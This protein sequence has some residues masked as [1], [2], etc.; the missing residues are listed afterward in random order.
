MNFELEVKECSG[1]L[2]AEPALWM[3]RFLARNKK[4]YESYTPRISGLFLSCLTAAQTKDES[5]IRELAGRLGCDSEIREGMMSCI[6]GA[7][8][9]CDARLAMIRGDQQ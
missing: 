5:T 2:Q 1:L 9:L 8:H 6:Y 4:A 7:W 3:E